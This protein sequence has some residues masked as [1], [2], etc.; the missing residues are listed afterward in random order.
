MD[1]DYQVDIEKLSKEYLEGFEG[2]QILIMSKFNNP[3]V[4]YGELEAGIYNYNN[5]EISF[6]KHSYDI[7]D[8]KKE[9]EFLLTDGGPYKFTHYKRIGRIMRAIFPSSI[10][11]SEKNLKPDVKNL[12]GE[13]YNKL[14]LRE[15]V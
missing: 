14:D 3:S 10:L 12:I 7:S 6:V 8:I 9:N 4:N 2:S 1:I 5:G 13:I 15:N 11:S